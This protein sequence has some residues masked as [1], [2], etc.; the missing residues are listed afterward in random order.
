MRLVQCVSVVGGG[1]CGD[2]QVTSAWSPLSLQK[3]P[4]LLYKSILT[5]DLLIGQEYCTF[6]MA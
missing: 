5:V 2:A 1:S 3:H 6:E 4:R